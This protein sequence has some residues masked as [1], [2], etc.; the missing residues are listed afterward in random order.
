MIGKLTGR[1]L[2]AAKA[3]GRDKTL[4]TIFAVA[5][6]ARIAVALWMYVSHGFDAQ[7]FEF[8]DS[9]RYLAVA[10]NLLA[11]HGYSSA[12]EPPFA[13]D[14]YRTPGYP[15]FLLPWLAAFRSYL[16]AVATQIAIG[17]LVP[18]FAY[19]IGL[20]LSLPRRAVIFAAYWNALFP[21]TIVWGVSVITESLFTALFLAGFLVFLRWLG[22]PRSLRLAAVFAVVW[23]VA[24]LVRPVMEP[25]LAVALVTLL[26]SARKEW[27]K[28]LAAAAIAVAVYVAVMSPW[29]VWNRL[30]FGK[31]ES[32]SLAWMNIQITYASGIRAMRDGT[33]WETA[34]VK[35]EEEM[36]AKYGLT[37]E[38]RMQPRSQELLK[39]LAIEAISAAPREAAT[40]LASSFASFMTHDS[41]ADILR[42]IDAIPPIESGVS[43]TLVLLEK[44][45]AGI[46]DIFSKHGVWIVIPAVMRLF[47]ILMFLG[48]VV[49]TVV[50]TLRPVPARYG[51]ILAALAIF[52]MGAM[53]T[54]IGL[55]IEARHRY[56][57]EPLY[58]LLGASGIA[59][60]YGWCKQAALKNFK[61]WKR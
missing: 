38:V 57:I 4:V 18:V 12:F 60:S 3:S 56:P 11:G 24:G 32:T 33:P 2:S 44:G 45:P 14:N 28:T 34:H 29:L 9:T 1:A 47:W 7:V 31:W 13:P 36:A 5:L 30:Q 52:G 40:I 53:A 51:Q 22:S 20:R 25:L 58:L 46:V 26:V 37:E 43:G 50:A 23:G 15:F 6:I 39:R 48:T 55:G 42:R 49:S 16:P 61:T 19:L 21:A 59:V 27:K 41:T 54:T 8:G 35:V 17:A 10:K